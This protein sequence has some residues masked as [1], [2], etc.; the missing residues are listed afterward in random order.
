MRGFVDINKHNNIAIAGAGLLGRLIAWQLL[1]QQHRVTLYE[2]GAFS[3]SPAAAFTA[4]G[5]ISPLSE[6]VV[7]EYSV[8]EM[9]M[10]ALRQWPEWLA[11]FTHAQR[12]QNLFSQR[13]SLVIAHPQDQSE[14]HQ[15]EQEL[16]FILGAPRG[17]RRVDQQEIHQLEPDIHSNFQSGL[18]LEDEGHLNN[19]A[20][21]DELFAEI[22]LLGGRCIDQCPVQVKAHQIITAEGAQQ[23]D[24]VIDCRGLGAKT[25][26]NKLRGV[27][28]ETLHVETRE[29][30]LQRP[31]RLMHPRYQLYIV[32]KPDHRF[33]IG[34]TQIESEDR[35]PMS[36]QSS[37]ELSS[38]LYTLSPAFAEARILEMDVN[39]RPAYMDNM[40]KVIVED[41]L[42][43]A[44]GLF[45]HGYL[46]APAVVSNV[47]AQVMN[48]TE[49]PFNSL[50]TGEN[51]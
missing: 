20:L 38:A 50:L 33:I 9:G 34:A 13:G 3:P 15:L 16:A 25:A 45:R 42:I 36:L 40:P 18:L 27:R 49:K 35:S 48:L 1:R 12:T 21:L 7:S 2:A 26:A 17:Y 4:A 28:G 23:Y 43:Q 44:N 5:M 31:V 11:Q 14:L 37:L 32:P 30:T 51:C 39:L 10:F 22:N 47:L 29:I 46:L 24:L 41:G 19:R 8:Y 6:A